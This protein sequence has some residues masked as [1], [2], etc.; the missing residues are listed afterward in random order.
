M[1]CSGVAVNQLLLNQIFNTSSAILNNVLFVLQ[2]VGLSLCL[3]TYLPT[4]IGVL[5][6]DKRRHEVSP[7]G[8]R[9]KDEK[10]DAKVLVDDIRA[11]FT[12]LSSLNIAGDGQ[13]GAFSRPQRG[14]TQTQDH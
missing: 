4:Y 11:F 1:K 6:K 8:R 7:H 12:L 9:L 10:E 13:V 2:S 3:T 14:A 5:S